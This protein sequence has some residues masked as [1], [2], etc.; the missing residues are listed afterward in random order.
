[1]TYNVFG[2][3]LNPAQSNPFTRLFRSLAVT[4]SDLAFAGNL[5]GWLVGRCAWAGRRTL[6]DVCV[7]FVCATGTDDAG[8]RAGA[9]PRSGLGWTCPPHFCQRSFLRLMQIR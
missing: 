7:T 4:F 5:P 6:I 1:M 8:Q 2:G 9:S 3:T